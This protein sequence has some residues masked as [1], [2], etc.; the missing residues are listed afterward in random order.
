MVVLI[1][2]AQA[3]PAQQGIQAAQTDSKFREAAEEQPQNNTAKNAC[4]D[5]HVIAP[6]E[7]I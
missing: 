2:P 6:R 7:I 4:Q 5:I 3:A 1:Q